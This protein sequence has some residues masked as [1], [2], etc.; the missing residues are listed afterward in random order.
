MSTCRTFT[1]LALAAALV[2][3]ASTGAPL[4][5]TPA[6]ADGFSRS[7]EV[8]NGS[9][10]T[11]THLYATGSARNGWGHNKLGRTVLRPG[12]SARINFDDGNGTCAYEVRVEFAGGAG[13]QTYRIDVC[14]VTSYTFF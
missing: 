2:C 9:G 6:Q 10:A 5:T 4:I 7:V 14:S 1:G 13:A 8:V 3:G 12:Q 11:L